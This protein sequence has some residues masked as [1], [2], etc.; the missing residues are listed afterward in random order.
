MTLPVA[1]AVV[2]PAVHAQAA[3]PAAQLVAR[4][5]GVDVTAGALKMKL[6]A[7]SDDLVRVRIAR[8]GVYP[9]DASWAVLPAQRKARAKV[10]ATSDGFTTASLRVR[11]GAGGAV[12]FETLDGKVI[13]ADAAPRPQVDGKAF[14]VAKT[15]PVTEHFY[16]LGDKTGRTRSA[17]QGIRRLEHRCIRL[18][19][20]R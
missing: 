9:E 15:L 5:D 11:V 7:L 12:T 14:T 4:A 10:T 19:Q 6:I 13:S 2:A 3:A 16:G 8:D 20:Q 1:F 18:H 17:R